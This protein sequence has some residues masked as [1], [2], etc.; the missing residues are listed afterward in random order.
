MTEADVAGGS[1]V[2]HSFST[3]L[4]LFQSI[5][6]SHVSFEVEER[7][8]EEAESQFMRWVGCEVWI[9]QDAVWVGR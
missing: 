8:G 5:P 2:T 7:K 6:T 3:P 9:T 4:L 1:G